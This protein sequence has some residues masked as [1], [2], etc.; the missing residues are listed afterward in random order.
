MTSLAEH[1]RRGALY[2]FP[3]CCRAQYLVEAAVVHP[4]LEALPP[5]LGAPARRALRL[6]PRHALADGLV[7]CTAHAAWWLL[8]G[9]PPV[10]PARRNRA[11]SC[12]ETRDAMERVGVRVLLVSAGDVD[13]MLD[14]DICIHVLRQSGSDSP[15]MAEGDIHIHRCPWCGHTLGADA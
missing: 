8:T 15:E 14:T 11:E 10:S 2:G 13:G 7:P 4:L 5:P 9:R 12:C 6:T 3:A 1:W